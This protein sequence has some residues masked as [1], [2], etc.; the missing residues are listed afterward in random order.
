[1]PLPDGL[2]FDLLAGALR[3]DAQDNATFLEV[4]AAKLEDALPG[5]VQVH[6]A[7]GLLRKTHPVTAMDVEL[8]EDRFHVSAPAPGQLE[9]RHSRAVRGIVLKSDALGLSEWI[10][11][12]SQALVAEAARSEA[13]RTALERLLR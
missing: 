4:L 11:A 1:V 5:R 10:D 3:A 2:T 9:T 13:D 12:L 7:G 8:G 6:R